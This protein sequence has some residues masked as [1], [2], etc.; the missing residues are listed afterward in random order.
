MYITTKENSYGAILEKWFDGRVQPLKLLRGKHHKIRITEVQKIVHLKGK[1]S[2]VAFYQCLTDNFKTL[3]KCDD[4]CTSFTLPN[5]DYQLCNYT[6][7]KERAHCSCRIFWDLY[8]GDKCR[9][10]KL[11]EVQQY[12][13]DKSDSR[14]HGSP[15]AFHFSLEYGRPNSLDGYR[16]NRPIKTVHK[17]TPVWG[18]FQLLG[19]IGG[20][21]GMFVGFS[22]SGCI[23]WIINL[24]FKLR[25]FVLKL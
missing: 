15:D 17:E 13:V 10:E 4:P 21:M 23:V 1:C 16:E 2:N 12:F 7:N 8:E 11:C 24:T 20:T 3:N 6:E 19:N 5:L 14:L 22:F 18:P 9:K 25:D